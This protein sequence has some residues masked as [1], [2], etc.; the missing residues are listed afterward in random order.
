[1]PAKT[2][3]TGKNFLPAKTILPVRFLPW[4]KPFFSTDWQKLANPE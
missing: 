4:K 2:I 1:L 3:F